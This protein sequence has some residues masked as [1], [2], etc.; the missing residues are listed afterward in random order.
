MEN[1]EV[2]LMAVTMIFELLLNTKDNFSCV[3]PILISF[4]GIRA[5][6]LELPRTER[7]PLICRS[8]SV[9]WKSKISMFDWLAESS[10]FMKLPFRSEW[11]RVKKHCE[12]VVTFVPLS[13]ILDDEEPINDKAA[14]AALPA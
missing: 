12:P 13:W 8:V 6:K 11:T 9:T 5:S 2:S 1:P 7:L 14:L 10:R 3:V 4:P